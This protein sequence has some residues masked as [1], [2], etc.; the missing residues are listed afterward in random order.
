MFR[1]LPVVTVINHDTLV[2]KGLAALSKL[3]SN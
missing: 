2:I 3:A 1:Y